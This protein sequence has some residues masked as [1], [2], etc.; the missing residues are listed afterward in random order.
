M[1]LSA[2]FPGLGVRVRSPWFLRRGDYGFVLDGRPGE[3]RR[4]VSFSIGQA[5]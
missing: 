4:R 1:A 5:F 3:S 2:I